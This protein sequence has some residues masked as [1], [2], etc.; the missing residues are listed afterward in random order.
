M[1]TKTSWHFTKRQ[2]NTKKFHEKGTKSQK[3]KNLILVFI[4]LV[5]HRL[6]V[7]EL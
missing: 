3:S 5:M 4:K 7:T 1:S 2:K 6:K